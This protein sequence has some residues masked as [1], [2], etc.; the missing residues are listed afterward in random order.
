[1]TVL[2]AITVFLSAFLLFLVQPLIGKFI[3]PWF[4]GTPA[5]WTTCM[6]FFQIL[7]LG[8]Y[9]YSHILASRL[10]TRRQAILH[11]LLLAATLVLLPITPSESWKSG[12]ALFPTWK[13]LG[14]LLASVGAAYFLLSATGPLLQSWFSLSLPKSSPYRLYSLSNVGS[15]LAIVAYPFLIE[16]TLGLRT[17]TRVWSLAYAAFTICCGL[18]AVRLF[19]DSRGIMQDREGT[20]APDQPAPAWGTRMAWVSLT[21]LS[22]VML[23]ATTNQICQDMAVVPMLW[24]LPLG[25]YLLSF[26]LCFHSDR[27]YS[28]LWYG[29]ALGAAA[30]QTCFVLFRGIHV[31]IQWQI[32]SYSLTL[33]VCCMVCH[34]E[35]VHLKPAARHL[36]SFYL[37]IAVGGAL[38]GVFV[39]FLSPLVFRDYWELHL[40]LAGTAFIFLLFLFRDPKGKLSHGRPFPAW[41]V[42]YVAFAGLVGA[43]AAQI[44]SSLN[45]DI[46]VSRGFFGVL[47]VLEDSRSNPDE[48]RM[49]LMHGRIEHGYQLKAPDKRYWPTSYFGPHSGIGLTLRLHP[50]RYNRATALPMKVGIV[51]LGTG[52]LATYGQK[53]DY[54]R[55]YEINPDVLRISDQ[56]FSYRRDSAASVDVILGD[57]RVSMENELARH[58][59]QEFDVL[60]VDAFSSDAIPVHLL[61][62]ECY[63]TYWDHLKKDGIL[64]IH[65]S[66]RYFDLSPVVRSLAELSLEPGMNACMIEDDGSALEET[67]KTRWILVTA[68]Q[69]F[70]SEKE[71]QQ[72]T[73]AWTSED[74][75]PLLFTDDYTNLFRVMIR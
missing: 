49:V 8:G 46:E 41:T 59:P 25:L 63:Q 5:V 1:L 33:F 69:K 71:V 56:Y 72:A 51:G 18:C 39:N 28:R 16:P 37:M 55:F 74:L 36:T 48:S 53:G 30:A 2:F 4:G 54:Y 50:N 13:I 60:A 44:H 38:G 47:R 40:G 29:I 68:N 34:G 24:L 32:A 31:G 66:N 62:K 11:L 19:R 20:L 65:I 12:D 70:L 10:T 45:N 42:L 7:L 52:T 58:Q 57:A 14:L 22:S 27:W 26:I 64:A 17:Q 15:L 35:L 43:L 75:P 23:L 67:D 73:R 9:A 21:A 6:L 61:T 3:L